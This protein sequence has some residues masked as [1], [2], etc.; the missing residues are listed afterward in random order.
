[1]NVKC[2]STFIGRRRDTG[3]IENI[4]C[5]RAGNIYAVCGDDGYGYVLWGFSPNNSWNKKKFA[6]LTTDDFQFEDIEEIVQVGVPI[7]TQGEPYF[8]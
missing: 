5:P 8:A 1:M 6:P 3:I 4:P 2:I 7:G